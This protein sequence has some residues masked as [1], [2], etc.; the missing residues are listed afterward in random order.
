MYL[1]NCAISYLALFMGSTRIVCKNVQ[2]VTVAVR[3]AQECLVHGI[4]GFFCIAVAQS[5]QEGAE[6]VVTCIRYLHTNQ[7]TAKVVPVVTIVK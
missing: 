6:P 7:H 4:V 2:L 3:I 1:S 5:I